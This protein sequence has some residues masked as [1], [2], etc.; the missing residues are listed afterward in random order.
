MWNKNSRFPFKE[1]YALFR[2]YFKSINLDAAACFVPLDYV[3]IVQFFK[4]L[5][6]L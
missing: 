3:A 1:Q 6:I 4:N 5:D 2:A